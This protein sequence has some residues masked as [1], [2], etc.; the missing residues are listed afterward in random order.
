[1]SPLYYILIWAYTRNAMVCYGI[2]GIWLYG[3]MAYGLWALE[4][5]ELYSNT[6]CVP[7]GMYGTVWYGMVCYSMAYGY[8]AYGHIVMA[9]SHKYSIV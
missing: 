8:M 1:M 4:Q 7:Y 2:V 5:A 3:H 9:Y 6:A